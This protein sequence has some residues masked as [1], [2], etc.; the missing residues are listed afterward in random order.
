RVCHAHAALS[1]SSRPQ[2]PRTFV[3]PSSYASITCDLKTDFAANGHAQSG[4]FLVSHNSKAKSPVARIDGRA[5]ES[6]RG[7][8]QR[9]R[10]PQTRTWPFSLGFP[11]GQ[12]SA[13]RD[14]TKF[15]CGKIHGQDEKRQG[16]SSSMA[17]ALVEKLA[18]MEC[19]APPQHIHPPLIP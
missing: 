14:L 1:K 10:I 13:R 16:E 9:N 12:N 5:R 18:K 11:V 3:D 6:L 15:R 2:W 7:A 19:T 4:R 8:G 17:Y